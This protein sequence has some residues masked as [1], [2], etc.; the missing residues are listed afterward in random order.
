MSK[1]E[2][3]FF[4]MLL[5]NRI[6]L[7]NKWFI[8]RRFYDIQV[9]SL[10]LKHW[11][12]RVWDKRKRIKGIIRVDALSKYQ[13]LTN[14]VVFSQAANISDHSRNIW[15]Q[16]VHLGRRTWLN[17]YICI[18]YS[19]SARRIKKA[20]FVSVLKEFKLRHDKGPFAENNFHKL[21]PCL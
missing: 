10:F 16:Y 21:F 9:C 20:V 4:Y 15:E 13:V 1:S 5:T 19:L 17:R 8:G 6:E 11:Y 3:F 18:I 14:I 7:S 2:C 12:F